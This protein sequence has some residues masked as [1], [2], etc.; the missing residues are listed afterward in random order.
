MRLMRAG[1][2]VKVVMALDKDGQRSKS[3]D[4]LIEKVEREEWKKHMGWADLVLMSDNDKWLIPVD[5][6]KRKGFPVFAPSPESAEL[7]LDRRKGQA[8]FDAHG[9][10]TVPYKAFSDG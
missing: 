9:I 5:A 1:H 4:G 6:Y 7:E 8:F 3:G 2:H 10:R